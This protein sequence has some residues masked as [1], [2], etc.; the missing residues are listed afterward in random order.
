MKWFLAF[1][2]LTTLSLS[3]SAASQKGEVVKKKAIET[4]AATKDYTIEQKDEFV[5]SL[6][7]ELRDLDQD[8]AVMRAKANKNMDAQLNTLEE[9]RV[10]LNAKIDRLSTASKSAWSE[11]RSGIQSAFRE[12][13]TS[14]NKA[15]DKFNEQR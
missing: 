8:I 5:T 10:E 15:T 14:F 13:K 12:V 7:N 4:Y 11:M 9:K 3:L 1:L 2:A 6:K